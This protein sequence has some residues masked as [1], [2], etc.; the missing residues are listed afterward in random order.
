MITVN[1]LHFLKASSRSIYPQ[2]RMCSLASS[3]IVHDTKNALSSS[4]PDAS[5]N[6]LS[7]SPIIHRGYDVVNNRSGNTIDH[8]NMKSSMIYNDKR[9]M[10]N[11]FRGWAYQQVFLNRRIQHKRNAKETHKSSSTVDNNEIDVDRILFLEHDHVYTLG[12][13]ADENYLTFLKEEDRQRLCRKR[14]DVGDGSRLYGDSLKQRLTLEERLAMTVEAEVN[15]F[16]KMC[17][18]NIM[19]LVLC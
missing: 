19:V 17:N 7:R 4:Q 18:G 6:H 13:G 11:Y 10:L 3:S 16:G 5:K 2:C 15:S 14:R 12:R 1:I 9:P 8:T